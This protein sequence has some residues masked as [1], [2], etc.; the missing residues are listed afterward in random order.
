MTTKKN[1]HYQ[2]DLKI[3]NSK[4]IGFTELFLSFLLVY[5]FIGTD[6]TKPTD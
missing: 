5:N 1:Q 3:L 4:Y 6:V 2:K